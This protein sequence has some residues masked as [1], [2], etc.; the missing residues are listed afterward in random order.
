MFVTRTTRGCSQSAASASSDT[1]GMP[2]PTRHVV[3]SVALA[4]VT[5][6]GSLAPVVVQAEDNPLAECSQPATEPAKAHEQWNRERARLGLAT[7]TGPRP[8]GPAVLHD[9]DKGLIAL[10]SRH[11]AALV[12]DPE[13]PRGGGA[14]VGLIDRTIGHDLLAAPP[15]RFEPTAWRLC[16]GPVNRDPR[17]CG[18][19]EGVFSSDQRRGSWQKIEVPGA[20]AIAITWTVDSFEMTVEYRLDEKSL[21]ARARVRQSGSSPEQIVSLRFPV[22]PGLGQVGSA[23]SALVLPR[24]NLG[25]VCTACG[26]FSDLYPRKY[27]TM[28][29]LG[30]LSGKH[31]LYIGAHDP[32]GAPKRFMASGPEATGQSW[33]EMYPNTRSDGHPAIAPA[34]WTVIRPTCDDRGWP[35]LAQAYRDWVLQETPWGQAPLIR[36]REDIPSDLREG[37]WWFNESIRGGT[38]IARLERK[39]REDRAAI[40]QAPTIH[41]WY[42]WYESGMDRGNPELVPKKDVE[43]TIEALQD[44]KTSIIPY[45]N[46]SHSDQSGAPV[47]MGR[48]TDCDQRHSRYPD[49]WNHVLRNPDGLPAFV[50]PASGACLVRMDTSAPEWRE[51]V[52]NAANTIVTALGAAGV[53]LDV[54]GSV[55]NGSW[56]RRDERLPR[57]AWLVEADRSLVETITR[58]GALVVVEGSLE[59]MAGSAAF[60]VNYVPDPMDAAPLFPYVYHDRF[61][62]AGMRSRPPEDPDVLA[63]KLG[64]SLVW[65]LQPGLSN[66][67]LR[68]PEGKSLAEWANRI[69]DARRALSP[70]IAYGRF[71]G[72]PAAGHSVAPTMYSGT[73]CEHSRKCGRMTR[74]AISSGFFQNDEG[75]IILLYA[76]SGTRRARMSI[77]IPTYLRGRDVVMHRP[78]RVKAVDVSTVADGKEVVLAAPAR[79]IRYLTFERPADTQEARARIT[80]Q[81][82]AAEAHCREDT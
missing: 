38:P 29:W 6:T 78:G 61:I 79:S 58:S 81:K 64:L 50:R 24:T 77:V 73:W 56:N 16:V 36:S 63:M 43:A 12:L 13:A 9:R 25:L 55:S 45:M 35:A 71:L 70:W 19:S 28:P 20:A 4:L 62:L 40:E 44:E 57:G 22:L 23:E 1:G 74:S 51:A 27:Q 66:L 10:F 76:N 53:Y 26:S 17:S 31:G 49:H 65:G 46:A 69:V 21:R 67:R 60:G 7:W 42:G 75:D 11:R 5:L 2:L 52:A 32:A 33:I 82:S 68:Q 80:S 14:V 37:A 8:T 18:N 59:Q 48:P 15:R 34:W 41:H 72:P 47:A 30:Y 3:L 39:T 54:I